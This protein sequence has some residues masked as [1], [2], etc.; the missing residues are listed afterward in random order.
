VRPDIA[1][2][3]EPEDPAKG[4][5][6]VD[7]EMTARAPHTGRSFVDDSVRFVILCQ[8]FLTSTLDLSTSDLLAHQ[9]LKGRLYAPVWPFN[10]VPAMWEILPVQRR[11]SSLK[12]SKM[13]RR[14]ALP[15]K[16]RCE[17]ILKNIQSLMD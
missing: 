17:S 5:D 9:E 13:A 15:G 14:S 3:P 11:P 4:Y 2:K 12:P 8:I 1:F 6:T 10:L 7:Q 16:H